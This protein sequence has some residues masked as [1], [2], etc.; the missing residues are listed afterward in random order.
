MAHASNV[1]KTLDYMYITISYIVIL[2]LP[3]TEVYLVMLYHHKLLLSAV[4]TQGLIDI[5]SVHLFVCL[6]ICLQLRD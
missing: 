1:L 3:E 2:H 5:G 6:S 4:Y